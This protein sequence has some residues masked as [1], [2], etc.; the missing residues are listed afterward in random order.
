MMGANWQRDVQQH[1]VVKKFA[2]LP[3]V[4]NSNKRVW[5]AHYYIK[6]THYDDMGK[7]PIKC[8][9]W[10]YTYTENEYLIQVLKGA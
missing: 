9:S 8:S 7:P 1:S 4:T 5:L 3:V 6:Y 10:E 2:W